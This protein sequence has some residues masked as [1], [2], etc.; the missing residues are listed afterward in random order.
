[1]RWFQTRSRTSPAAR[2]SMTRECRWSCWEDIEQLKALL[3]PELPLNTSTAAIEGVRGG[4]FDDQKTEDVG[5][6]G[7]ADAAHHRPIAAGQRRPLAARPGEA[8]IEEPRHF[9]REAAVGHIALD[10]AQQRRA[11]FDIGD[12]QAA[13]AQVVVDHAVAGWTRL[14]AARRISAAEVVAAHELRIPRVVI[15]HV[16][17]LGILTVPAKMHRAPGDG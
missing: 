14:P 17:T 5:A 10:H 11:H 1:M 8:R 4:E 3:D 15:D 7:D 16:R 2:V 6:R 12:E 9:N 13:A